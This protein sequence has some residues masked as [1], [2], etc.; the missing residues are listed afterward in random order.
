M[1]QLEFPFTRRGALQHYNMAQRGHMQKLYTEFLQNSSLE[2]TKERWHAW[3]IMYVDS[4]MAKE[5]SQSHRDYLDIDTVEAQNERVL[6]NWKR[7]PLSL[8]KSITDL[9]Y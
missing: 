2:S 4:G 5:Y 6:N 7:R 8:P 3:E 9:L 1:Q